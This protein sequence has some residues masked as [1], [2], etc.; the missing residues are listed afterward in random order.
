M[1][2]KKDMHSTPRGS[3]A[4]PVLGCTLAV[5]FAAAAIGYAG[6]LASGRQDPLQS[7]AANSISFNDEGDAPYTRSMSADTARSSRP[8]DYF[9]AQFPP[10]KGEPAEHVQAF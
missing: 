9:P 3:I 6:G 2:L 4:L 7:E 1:T 8:A 10:P 5:A